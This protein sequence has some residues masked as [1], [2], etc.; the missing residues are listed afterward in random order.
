[1]VTVRGAVATAKSAAD[2]LAPQY[3]VAQIAPVTR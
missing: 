2:R 1:M 3:A